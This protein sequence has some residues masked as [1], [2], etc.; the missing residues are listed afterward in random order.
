MSFEAYSSN[1]KSKENFKSEEE[2]LTEEREKL[3]ASADRIQNR[4]ASY[5]KSYP[6][7]AKFTVQTDFLDGSVEIR[8]ILCDSKD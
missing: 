7:L 2:K 5:L 3:K 4:I 8:L 6:F 1:G